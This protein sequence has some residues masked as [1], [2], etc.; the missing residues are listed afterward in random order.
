MSLQRR[1]V[2]TQTHSGEQ[3]CER[4]DDHLQAREKGLERIP[5]R[6]LQ[7]EAT[8]LDTF[9]LTCSLLHWETANFPR[10]GHPGHGT[11]SL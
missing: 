5:P 4:E 10:A 8:L 2:W 11:L 6:S 1:A 3:P 9:I 7:E